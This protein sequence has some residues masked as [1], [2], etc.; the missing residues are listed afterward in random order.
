MKNMIGLVNKTKVTLT[1]F[2]RTLSNVSKKNGAAFSI[3]E[4]P[5]DK[6][7]GICHDIPVDSLE[8]FLRKEGVLGG[9]TP[10]Y[11]LIRVSIPDQKEPV[12]SLYE[13]RP[14][15]LSELSLPK[16]KKALNYVKESIRGAKCNDVEHSDMS[17]AK[18]ELEDMIRLKEAG[19][20]TDSNGYPETF[21]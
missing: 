8:V 20:A 21:D 19:N 15:S 10:S 11:A 7:E 16:V 13:L 5:S 2:K 14:V 9:S 4:S 18:K 17:A 12:L 6:V 3:C 1:G